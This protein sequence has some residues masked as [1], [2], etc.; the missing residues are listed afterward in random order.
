[1][2]GTM[3]LSWKHILVSLVA[4]FCGQAAAGAES[5]APNS[6]QQPGPVERLEH[7]LK[8]TGKSIEETVKD[9]ANKLED[10][11]LPEKT[12]RKLKQTFEDV[13]QGVER[14]GKDIEKKFQ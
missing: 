12:E 4:A 11:K 3:R 10:E 8:E 9:A 6:K 1:M 7:S 2:L 14:V 13:V 5:G